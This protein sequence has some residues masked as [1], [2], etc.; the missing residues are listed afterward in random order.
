MG[1]QLTRPIHAL[2]ELAHRAAL[3]GFTGPIRTNAGKDVL[4]RGETLSDEQLTK[5]DYYV[6]GVVGK[7]PTGN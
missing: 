5:M 3:V 4:G 2:H 7:V 1:Q 6:E